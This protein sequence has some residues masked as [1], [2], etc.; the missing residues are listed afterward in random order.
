VDWINLISL[1]L[2]PVTG[3]VTWLFS[4]PKRKSEAVEGMQVT[5]DLLFSKNQELYG[6]I[7]ELQERLTAA[8]DELGEHKYTLRGLGVMENEQLRIKNEQL[9]MKN[10]E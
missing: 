7:I 8:M 3:V 1:L 10:G 6:K 5:I 4:K 2:V 9:R